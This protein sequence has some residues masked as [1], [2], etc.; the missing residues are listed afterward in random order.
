MNRETVMTKRLRSLDILRGL[1]IA[2]MITVNNP[3]SWD[4]IFAPLRHAEW[5]GMTPTD[6][7]FPFFMFIMGISTCFSLKKFNYTLNKNLLWKIVKRTVLLYLIGV[8]IVLVMMLAF[9]GT[10]HWS[11]VRFSG[12]LARLAIC[13]GVVS[14]LA[15]TLPHRTFPWIIAGLLVVYYIILLLGNGF[16]QGPENIL[17]KVDC[18][19]LGTHMYNDHQIDPEGVLSTIPSV[20]HVMLGFCCGK[21][22]MQKIDIEQKVLRLLLW[23]VVGIFIGYLFSYGCPISK[24]VWS[25]SFVFVACGGA[26]ALLGVLIWLVDVKGC[27][28]G[29]LSFR[30]IGVN[31]LFCYVLGDLLFILFNMSL[32]GM[33]H[34]FQHVLINDVF[35]PI[36]GA[37]EWASLLYALLLMIIVWGVA[38]ILY[39]KKIYIKL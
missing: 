2:W 5:V 22:F 17:S 30:I 39:K 37:G 35:N 12:V 11:E 14:L 3:G 25:P 16:L 10:I 27:C 7:V 38:A 21:I 8:A 20:A 19:V 9:Y 4:Y 24:K 31:P 6:L 33:P 29:L 15:S 26:A 32:P 28:K 23:G 18:L 1:T 36:L 34:G 13:Y